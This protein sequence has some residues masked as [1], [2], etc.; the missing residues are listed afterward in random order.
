MKKFII[1]L[2]FD[3]TVVTHEFPEIGEP[4]GA[5]SVLRRLVSRGHKLVL[6]TMR[7]NEHLAAAVGWFEE[8]NIFLWNIQ[9]NPY[10]DSWTS[11]PKA[12]GHIYI[13][14]AA[15]GCPLV[16]SELFERPFVDWNVVEKLLKDKGIL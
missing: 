4:V 6:F 11:S 5:E 16:E 2:D 7:S 1:C 13:D 15:L 14:D 8:R 12:Y 10:Q 9:R 3:G